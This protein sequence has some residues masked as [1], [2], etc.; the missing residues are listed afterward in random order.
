MP[1]P[2]GRWRTY[3]MRE[4]RGRTHGGGT[5]PSQPHDIA[6]S[7]AM[8]RLLWRESGAEAATTCV[9]HAR[10]AQCDNRHECWV[11]FTGAAKPCKNSSPPDVT[12]E[13]D[14]ATPVTVD[15]PSE[16]YPTPATSPR[17]GGAREE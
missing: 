11:I 13:R 8:V 14:C 17:E 1:S 16:A 9:R 12:L 7:G 5:L 10:R 15:I 4:M 3:H 6:R 2:V